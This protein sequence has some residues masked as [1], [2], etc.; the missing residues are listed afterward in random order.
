M[1][2]PR[3]ARSEMLPR[4]DTGPY[5]LRVTLSH[6]ELA[7][8]RPAGATK[9]ARAN[10][11]GRPAHAERTAPQAFVGWHRTVTTAR[12]DRT[13]DTRRPTSTITH[14]PWVGNGGPH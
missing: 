14:A 9:T 11:R 5:G 8:A 4:S 3:K 2:F 13:P 12:Q 7:E 1:R 10:H 6:N